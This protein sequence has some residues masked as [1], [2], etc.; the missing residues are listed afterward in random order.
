MWTA[1]APDVRQGLHVASIAI[2]G[3][4]RDKWGELKAIVEAESAEDAVAKVRRAV[5]HN[6]A[7]P[8]AASPTR[9]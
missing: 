8:P 5:G 3:D 7:V 6:A 1:K 2:V 4:T 9:D